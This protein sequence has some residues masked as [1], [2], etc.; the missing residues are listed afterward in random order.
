V[1]KVIVAVDGGPASRAALGWVIDRARTVEMTLE[2]TTIVGIDS[3]QPEGD[4][5][6]TR[7][8][9]SLEEA[10]AAVRAAVPRVRV[11]TRMRKGVPHDT[12]ISAS[13]H[14][15]LIVVGTN[16]T[17]AI[18]GLTNST[19]PLRVAGHA[20]CTTVVVPA[21]WT[22][23]DGAIVAG[24]ADDETSDYALRLAAREADRRHQPLAIVHTWEPPAAS[25]QEP[26]TDRAA[27][28][29]SHELATTANR[30]RQQHPGLTVTEELST[31][32]AAAALTR[33]A[34]DCSLVVLGSRGRGAL[35]G[36]LLGSVSHS[37][38]LAMPAPVAVVPRRQ[39]AMKVYPELVDEDLI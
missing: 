24:W 38:L 11:R 4:A 19:L 6:R 17:S 26:A 36:L 23:R 12:L 27:G 22:P 18:A 7:S 13:R 31:S 5:K 3:A 16:K 32:P 9:R 1:E 28:A 34:A 25:G 8:E 20:R 30:V 35:T 14:A 21:S 2:I 37:V 29:K 15:D 33:R 10:L 39:A